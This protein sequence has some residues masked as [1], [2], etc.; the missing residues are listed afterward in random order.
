MVKGF[1]G[2]LIAFAVLV[3]GS[4]ALSESCGTPGTTPA[5]SPTSPAVPTAHPA[6]TELPERIHVFD[7]WDE[8]EPVR[9]IHTKDP[10][11]IASFTT[12]VHGEVKVAKMPDE[13]HTAEAL[14]DYFWLLDKAP[15]PSPFLVKFPLGSEVIPSCCTF[16]PTVKLDTLTKWSDGTVTTVRADLHYDDGHIPD[17]NSPLTLMCD[18]LIPV[19]D[20]PWVILSG[21]WDMATAGK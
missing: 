11:R 20:A 19:E 18:E 4:L 5:R 7:L 15:P 6:P 1:F 21:C 3:I 14:A 8:P 10:T 17:G 13:I 16:G 2:V 12:R 9:Y